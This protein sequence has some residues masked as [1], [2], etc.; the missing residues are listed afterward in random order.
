MLTISKSGGIGQSANM[1]I[2]DVLEKLAAVQIDINSMKKD[3]SAIPA[4]NERIGLIEQ[5]LNALETVKTD[6]TTLEQ[7]HA[8][9]QKTVN[10]I[11]GEVENIT[12]VKQEYIDAVEKYRVHMLLNEKLSKRWNIII[13]GILQE[14]NEDGTLMWE[15]RLDAVVKVQKFLR[16]VL[17]IEDDIIITDAHRMSVKLPRKGRSL[18]LIFKLSS[19]VDKGKIYKALHHL[20]TYNEDAIEKIFVTMEHL[21]D[22]M[23]KERRS[24]LDKFK[25]ARLDKLKPIWFADRVTGQYCL[26]IGNVIHKPAKMPDDE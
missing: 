4:M 26:R 25:Q 7:N 24:L 3:V 1:S 16:D 15:S 13:E 8:D 10:N 17:K 2:K 12:S 19:L 14:R 9:L 22:Q 18:P 6:I 21:P 23:Q 5:R 11:K 20:K